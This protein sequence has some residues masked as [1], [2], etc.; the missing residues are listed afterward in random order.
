MV[1]WEE[2]RICWVSDDLFTYNI[3]LTRM[4][5]GM[6]IQQVQ[7]GITNHEPALKTTIQKF[8]SYCDTLQHL[9]GNS[10]IPIPQHLP[11]KLASLCNNP[12]LMGDV[13]IH[14]VSDAPP[15]WLTDKSVHKG[16][17]GMLK[18]DRY[19]EEQ[20]RLG[21]EADRMCVWFGHEL[22]A[23]TVALHSPDSKQSLLHTYTCHLHSTDTHITLQL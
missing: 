3:C 5:A 11:T 4:F 13:W 1:R 15:L 14:T 17:H 8:N 7:K 2:N 21:I 23:V 16:I 18:I 22:A 6:K 12:S 10:N 9:A 20:K 19:E